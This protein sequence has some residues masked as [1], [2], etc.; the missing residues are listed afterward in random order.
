ML[1]RPGWRQVTDRPGFPSAPPGG[2]T[3]SNIRDAASARWVRQIV[4]VVN[5]VLRGKQNAVLTITLRNG[6][7]TT[8]VK[9]ARIGPFSAL[10]L[11]PLT[12]HAAADL[13]SATSVLAD[14]TTQKDG[15]V[16]FNHPNNAFADKTFNLLIIG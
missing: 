7:A 14:Q 13:Y 2:D 15:E 8:T 11:Q 16:V 9:D 3:A 6:F 4:D 1:W 10:I 12:A 5:S